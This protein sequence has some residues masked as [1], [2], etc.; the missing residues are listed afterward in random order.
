MPNC[1]WY[2]T[3]ED[4]QVIMQYV[5]DQ[6]ELQVWE[7]ASTNGPLRRFHS[8]DDVMNEFNKPSP[9]SGKAKHALHLTLYVE[10]ACSHGFQPRKRHGRVFADGLGMIQF[11]L[12]RPSSN[13]SHTNHNSRKRAERW[14]ALVEGDSALYWDFD[15]VSRVSSRVNRFIRKNGEAKLGSRVLLPGAAE[16]WRTGKASFFV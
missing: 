9:D 12:E 13:P 1:D 3:L 8:V 11:Y 6:D 7:L 15:L 2:G 5:L 16:L 14:D 10:G 4:H